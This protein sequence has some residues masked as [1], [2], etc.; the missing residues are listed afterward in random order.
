MEPSQKI[1]T[2]ELLLLFLNGYFAIFPLNM[3]QLV[4]RGSFSST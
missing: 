1:N 4:T 3:G 2:N